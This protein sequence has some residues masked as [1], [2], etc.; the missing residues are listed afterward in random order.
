MKQSKKLSFVVP[1]K[2][3]LTTLV[4]S[5]KDYRSALFIYSCYLQEN[6]NTMGCQIKRYGESDYL[7]RDLVSLLKI[8]YKGN[9]QRR[10]IYNNMLLIYRKF[11]F[12]NIY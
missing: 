1:D 11:G 4:E 3:R 6:Y 5:I 8:Y 2:S 10:N 9:I 12:N 7:F